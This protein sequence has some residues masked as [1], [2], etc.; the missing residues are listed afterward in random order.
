M[1]TQLFASIV[2]L[3]LLTGS[4]TALACSAP[5]DGILFDKADDKLP[6]CLLPTGEA[7]TTSAH[8]DNNCDR[9]V[10]MKQ[11]SCDS[12]SEPQQYKATQNKDAYEQISYDFTPDVAIE[13]LKDQETFTV[14]LE[15]TLGDKSAPELES[16]FDVEENNTV[17]TTVL[18]FRRSDPPPYDCPDGQNTFGCSSTNNTPTTPMTVLLLLVAGMVFQRRKRGQR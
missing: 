2:A 12:C 16:A 14:T 1:K 9:P 18:T 10:Q 6:K 13:Q 11:V 17:T 7:V 3:T 4:A 15:V 5:L 8:F